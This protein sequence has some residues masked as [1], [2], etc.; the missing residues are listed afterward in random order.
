MTRRRGGEVERFAEK[1]ERF[2]EASSGKTFPYLGLG[3]ELSAYYPDYP[4]Y[5]K[6][7]RELGEGRR[8]GLPGFARPVPVR[9]RQVHPRRRRVWIRA[10]CR[11]A[12]PAT[13]RLSTGDPNAAPRLP[14]AGPPPR[15]PGASP[16]EPPVL[17]CQ[18]L[19]PD[20]A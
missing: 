18:P 20:Q 4:D 17:A 12:G 3:G 15:R 9:G 5:P 1:V 19:R 13:G 6:G 7:V 8:P 10:Y 14:A 16:A 2:A 11:G